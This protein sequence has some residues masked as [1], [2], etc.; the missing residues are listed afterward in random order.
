M[1]NHKYSPKGKKEELLRR[2]ECTPGTRVRILTETIIWANDTSLDSPSVFWLTGQAGSGK[3]TIAYT[4]TRRFDI[5]GDVANPTILGGNFLC[6]RQFETTRYQNYIIRTIVYQLAHKCKSFADCLRSCNFDAI[7]YSVP[8]QIDELLVKPWM[9]SAG[10]RH[11]EPQYLIIIDAFDEIDDTGG[12]DFLCDLLDAINAHKLRGLKFFATS[13][14][15][16]DLLTHLEGLASKQLCRLE[17]VPIEEAQTDITTYVDAK[18][19]KIGNDERKELV[20]QAAGLFIYAATVVKHLVTHQPIEQQSLL[21]TLLATPDPMQRPTSPPSMTRR[22]DKLYHQILM[23]AFGDIDKNLVTKRKQILHTFLCTAERTSTSIVAGLLHNDDS[24]TEIADDVLSRLHA[25]L[26][27]KE[28]QVLWY[29]TSFRNFLL[30]QTRSGD[31]LCDEP[32]HHQRLTKFCFRVM[33]TG[34][35]FNIGVLRRYK[36]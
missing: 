7:D 19:P 27:T 35:R 29:H 33:G 12:S 10:N 15:S 28:D 26:Y 11:A 1:A 5:V 20:V 31:F 30:D 6:S 16:Q 23:E 8:D 22:L 24:S 36:M 2:E 4:I 32:A 21:K 3:T 14:P 34:L 25:V 17:N 9:E 18:L 13:R